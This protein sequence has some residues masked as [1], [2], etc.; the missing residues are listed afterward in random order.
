[1]HGGVKNVKKCTRHQ[2][3]GEFSLCYAA[4]PQE[5][6]QAGPVCSYVLSTS[7]GDYTGQCWLSSFNDV[8]QVLMGATADEMEQLRETDEAQFKHK[9]QMAC[10]RMWDFACRAKSDTFNDQVKVKY[11][12]MVARPV[13]FEAASKDLVD[14]IAKYGLL[15]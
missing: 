9:I 5:L 6:S 10:C 4:Y 13:D 1:M 15:D 2:N 7:V 12:V 8:A 3:I 14:K 11:Q